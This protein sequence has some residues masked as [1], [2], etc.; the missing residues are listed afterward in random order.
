MNLLLLL[1]SKV[2]QLKLEAA[3]RQK[4]FNFQQTATASENLNAPQNTFIFFEFPLLIW[5]INFLLSLTYYTIH[6][7]PGK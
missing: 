1:T 3:K 7:T 2:P 6:I 5:F 4:F